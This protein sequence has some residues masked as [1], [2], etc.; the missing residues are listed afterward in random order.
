MSE[1]KSLNTI[2]LTIGPKR[3]RITQEI[4][5]QYE[6]VLKNDLDTHA[7]K[8]A[9]AFEKGSYDHNTHIQCVCTTP[10]T[11]KTLKQR[12]GRHMQYLPEFGDR[13]VE[14]CNRTKEGDVM[15]GYIMKEHP[16][17]V[18]R[19]GLTEEE[20]NKFAEDFAKNLPNYKEQNVV[21]A[22]EKERRCSIK[23]SRMNEI[24][25]FMWK[26]LMYV[27]ILYDEIN[28]D[29]EEY[30][31]NSSTNESETEETGFTSGDNASD[32]SSVRTCT[33]RT[34]SSDGMGSSDDTSSNWSGGDSFE[35]IHEPKRIKKES[36][37]TRTSGDV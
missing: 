5:N 35:F 21:V 28:K 9:Y 31:F 36:R 22:S 27:T 26:N 16:D 32:Y 13:T 33:S 18:V 14:A 1:E 3:T 4:L 20:L 11:K 24:V 23:H 34:E 29:E 17:H 30:E 6:E 12:L 19:K 15:Y 25:D 37:K 10:E 8:Y 2:S 7:V